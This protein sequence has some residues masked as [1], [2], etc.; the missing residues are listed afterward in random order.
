MD[1][2]NLREAIRRE[3]FEPF[4]IRLADGRS[5]QINHPEFVAIGRRRAVVID[6]DDSC[7]WL[8]PLLVVSVEWPGSA[9]KRRGGNGS[10]KKHGPNP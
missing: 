1:L 10:P 7:I 5:L 2:N 9:P 3:P 6:K 8:E 4:V